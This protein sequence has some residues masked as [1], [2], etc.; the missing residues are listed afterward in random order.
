MLSDVYLSAEESTVIT[1]VVCVGV[2][3]GIVGGCSSDSGRVLELLSLYYTVSVSALVTVV[4][5]RN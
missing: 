4:V 5:M 2:G 1:I 3:V